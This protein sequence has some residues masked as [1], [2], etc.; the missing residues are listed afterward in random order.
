MRYAW[1]VDSDNTLRMNGNSKENGRSARQDM[2]QPRK[3]SQGVWFDVVCILVLSGLAEMVYFSAPQGRAVISADSIQYV[4]AAE[5]LLNGDAL[6]HFEMRKP[7]Y[8]L[9]LW[10]V[11]LIAGNIGWAAIVANHLLLATLP[12]G[13]YGFGLL[14]HSRVLGWMAALVTMAQLETTVWGNRMMSEALYA[15]LL[16]FGL[17]MACVTLS[18]S[19]NQRC[20]RGS[21][22]FDFSTF[23]LFDFCWL[24]SGTLLGLAWLTR[25]TAA[26]VIAAIVVVLIGSGI[27][28]FVQA[29]HG[30]LK[31]TPLP[32]HTMTGWKA[33][34]TEKGVR[35]RRTLQIMAFVA[36]VVVLV[37]FECALNAATTGRFAT[38]TGTKGAALLLRMTYHQGE[39]LPETPEAR[40]AQSWIPKREWGDAFVASDIDVWVARHRAL[41]VDGL[42]EW[43][44]DA[45]MAKIAAHLVW[46]DPLV[47]AASAG[48]MALIH[49]ARVGQSRNLAGSEARRK[50]LDWLAERKR[51]EMEELERTLVIGYTAPEYPASEGP[52]DMWWAMPEWPREKRDAFIARV[53]AAAQTKAP[54]G[55]ERI[56]AS[57]RYWLTLTPLREFMSIS[58]YVA[59]FLPACGLVFGLLW[60]R[61]RRGFALLAAVLLA[62]AALIGA[63][64]ITSNRFV[65][66]WIA[67][68]SARAGAAIVIPA[69]FLWN[70]VRPMVL[71]QY[72]RATEWSLAT[73][74]RH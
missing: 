62:E 12:A 3:P 41:H 73:W 11:G 16:T 43:E 74:V 23:R 66:V 68:D 17:L 52:S 35:R 40:R 2:N 49:F 42:N 65:F 69:A 13:A 25:G 51:M 61:N 28:D 72:Q 37:W 58:L 38:S 70:A 48:G 63:L 18:R 21:C 26:P 9:W 45:L 71:R 57:A 7:G 10:L 22:S 39:V 4:A 15:A 34:P 44:Y 30:Q 24:V 33:G 27:W 32:R 56:W 47:Y 64:V 59:Y 5:A 31:S 1:P 6:P 54:F 29:R 67:I 50:Q 55:G 53:H 19:R 46:R 14:L 20:D 60:G 36:P 8:I